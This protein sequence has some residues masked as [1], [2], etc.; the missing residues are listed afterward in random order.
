MKKLRGERFL[1]N[2]SIIYDENTS[3]KDIFQI[4]SNLTSHL[5]ILFCTFLCIQIIFLM[6][7]DTGFYYYYCLLSFYNICISPSMHCN[8]HNF[9]HHNLSQTSCTFAFQKKIVLFSSPY[10]LSESF[11]SSSVPRLYMTHLHKT[12]N[13]QFIVYAQLHDL[14]RTNSCI[15]NCQSKRK[16]KVNIFVLTYSIS[17]S[18]INHLTILVI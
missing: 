4:N 16:K 10:N 9:F 7:Y 11:I 15:Y 6:I 2:S 17:G 3:T 5:N 12:F 8:F 14:I 1:C 13:S 18:T